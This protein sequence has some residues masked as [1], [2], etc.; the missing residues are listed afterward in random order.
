MY[1]E[2][3][4]CIIKELG[5]WMPRWCWQYSDLLMGRCPLGRQDQPSAGRDI[6]FLSLVVSGSKF[7]LF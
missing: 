7:D 6:L 4:I 2:G 1:V 5:P 3:Y